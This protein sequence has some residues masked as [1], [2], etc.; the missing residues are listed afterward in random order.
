[1]AESNNAEDHEPSSMAAE[2]AHEAPDTNDVATG[3]VAVA[4]PAHAPPILR[5]VMNDRTYRAMGKSRNGRFKSMLD[6]LCMIIR[7]THP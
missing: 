5:M 1:M 4:P 2:A 3:P 6:E 7:E